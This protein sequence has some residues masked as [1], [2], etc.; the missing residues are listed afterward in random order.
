MRARQFVPFIFLS[1]LILLSLMSIF[2]VTARLL[3]A[4]LVLSYLAANLAAAVLVARN[5]LSMVPMLSLSFLILHVSYGL[6][7][8][9]G[10]IKFRNHWS[11]MLR[12][13][14]VAGEGEPAEKSAGA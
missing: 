5:R 1:S 13:S 4:G 8:L 2:S 11:S 6:G 12:P 7:S 10:L 14:K 9:V 3:L